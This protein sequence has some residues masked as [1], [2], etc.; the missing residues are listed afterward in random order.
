MPCILSCV[1]LPMWRCGRSRRPR[2]SGPPSPW[3]SWIA[4]QL[5]GADV[6]RALRVAGLEPV[7]LPRSVEDWQSGNR[8]GSRFTSRGPQDRGRRTSSSRCARNDGREPIEW[9]PWKLEAAF[10]RVPRTRKNHHENRFYPGHLRICR[11]LRRAI[12][13]GRVPRPGAVVPRPSAGV[14]RI[15]PASDLRRHRHLQ[16]GSRGVWGQGREHGRGRNPSDSRAAV[17]VAGRGIGFETVRPAARWTD[18][19][20]LGRRP[21]VETRVSGCRRAAAGGRAVF[22]RVQ[23]ARHQ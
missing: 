7:P 14:S 13:L 6:P 15:P 23:S 8:H 2:T 18:R 20:G 21:T 1:V 4:A 12:P 5:G 3:V 10:R 19:D 22:H 11:P 16:S 9:R 17:V